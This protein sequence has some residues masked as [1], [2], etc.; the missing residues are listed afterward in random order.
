MTT[1][2]I[3]LTKLE[4]KLRFFQFAFVLI[5]L[6]AVFFIITGFNRNP[7]TDLIQAK[8]IQVVDDDGNVLVSLW[9]STLGDGTISTR[10]KNGKLATRMISSTGGGGVLEIYNSDEKIVSTLE[11]TDKGTGYLS[12]K[13]SNG[14]DLFKVTYT[15]GNY[16]GWL[17]MY[18]YSGVN[19]FSATTAEDGGCRFNMYNKNNIRVC[20]LG[21]TDAGDGCLNVYN[22]AGQNLNGVWPK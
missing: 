2:E 10:S 8:K 3:K 1:L 21:T 18:N 17:G 11:T 15:S 7:V 14:N 9:S 6:I 22:S 19:T 5:I 20:Y 12:L 13:N 4:N 16:G